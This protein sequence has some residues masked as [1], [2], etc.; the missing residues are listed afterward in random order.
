MRYG[1]KMPPAI[2]HYLEAIGGMAHH[3]SEMLADLYGALDEGRAWSLVRMGDGEVHAL[4][5]IHAPWSYIENRCATVGDAGDLRQHSIQAI[6]EADWA[7]WHQDRWLSDALEAG[8]LLPP[9]WAAWHGEALT[10]LARHPTTEEIATQFGTVPRLIERSQ[11]AWCNLHMAL[12]RGFVER[13]LRSESLFLVGE[14]MQR[15]LDEVLRPA[16]L[17]ADA[18]VWGGE[19]T[20]STTAQASAI[21]SAFAASSARVMF[22]SLGVWAL[23]VVG[24]ARHIGRVG[25]DWGHAPNHHLNA[26]EPHWQYRINICCEDS[27][28]GTMAHYAHAGTANQCLPEVGF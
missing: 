5:G 14:P 9:G 16:G 19:T 10:R 28:A 20:V 4:R 26:A 24:W 1:E 8:G 11:F 12:R 3:I 6:R 17:G 27:P 25:I 15:W 23:P 22:A 21:A 2:T 7:G 13:V 18:L